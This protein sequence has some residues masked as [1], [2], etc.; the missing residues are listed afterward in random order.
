MGSKSA[1]RQDLMSLAGK[2]SREHEESDRDKIAAFTSDSVASANVDS[3]G[4]ALIGSVC[5][6]MLSG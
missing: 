5:G 6:E 2:K 1:S 3:I 4:G